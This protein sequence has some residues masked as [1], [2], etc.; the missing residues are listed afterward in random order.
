MTSTY[1]CGAHVHANGI[2]QHYLRYG[3]EGTPLVIVPGITSPAVTWGFVGERLGRYC[4]V[5]IL[6]VRGRGLSSS[7][8]DLDYGIDALARDLA[9]LLCELNLEGCTLLGHSMGARIISRAIARFDARADRV[10]LVDPPVSGPG[11]R[12]YPSRLPWYLDSIR[13]ARRGISAEEMKAYCP[14]WTEEQRALRA[15][16]LHSCN[17]GAVLRAFNDFHDVDF[18]QDLPSVRQPA[19]LIAAGKGGVILDEDIAEIRR[20]CPGI[21]V[22][23]V[24]D[25]GHMIPWDDEAGFYRALSNCL[26]IDLSAI[27]SETEA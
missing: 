7:G 26:D 14:T 25:A 15:Q 8:D 9:C 1:L 11:R 17:A 4:Q 19:S 18:H 5:Y 6:D 23:R 21:G 10:V 20:L 24:E 22:Q 16:W 2:R 3:N 27:I 13:D 12:E